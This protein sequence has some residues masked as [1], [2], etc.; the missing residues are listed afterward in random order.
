MQTTETVQIAGMSCGHCVRA[1]KAE[2][3][4]VAGVTVESVEV[5]RAT[6]RFDPDTVGRE[7]IEAAIREAGFKPQPA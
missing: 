2:L 7:Q 1:V 6:V 4:S 3:G 5:G